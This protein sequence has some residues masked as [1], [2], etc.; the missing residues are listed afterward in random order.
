MADYGVY[1][2]ISNEL[3][4]P[5]IF[6]K[7]ESAEGDCCTYAGPASVPADGQPHA[8]HLND[9]CIGR[10]AEGTAYFYAV[11]QGQLRQYAWYGSCPVW[12]PDNAA[13]GPGATDWN[14]TGHPLTVTVA[15]NPQTPGWTRVSQLIQHV[16]VLMLENRSL[17]HMLGFSGLT[18]TDAATGAPTRVDGL[19]GTESNSYDGRTYPVSQPADWAMPLDPGHEFTDVLA[20]LCGPDAVYQHGTYPSIDNSGYVANYAKSGGTSDP[21]EIMKCYRKGQLPVLAALAEEFALCDGW[22]ASMPGPTWPNR[23]FMMAASAGGLDHSPSLD[24]IAEW[25]TVSGFSFQNGTIFDALTS[26]QRQWRIYRGDQG[27]VAGSLPI[28]AGLKGIPLWDVAPYSDFS[29]D[30]ASGYYPWEF[31]LIE[32]NYGDVISN[33]Y[34]M[35]TSQHPMDDVRHGEALIKSTYEALRNSALWNASLLIVTWDEHGGFYDHAGGVPGGAPSPG[36]QIVTPGNVNKFGFTFR[37]Y[38]PRVPAVIVSPL[39]PKN[40][41]DHRTYDHASIPATVE[42]IFDLGALTQRDLHA[43]DVT[44][45]VSLRQPRPA[46]TVLPDLAGDAA[47]ESAGDRAAAAGARPAAD[48]PV[49][50]GSL[51]GFLQIAL[52]YD[53]ALSPPERRPEILARVSGIRSRAEA[54]RYLQEVGSKAATAKPA[55]T[56]G[57]EAAAQLPDSGA[58]QAQGSGAAFWTY[59]PPR[60]NT[61]QMV[62]QWSVRIEQ[63]DG[64]WS[65]SMTSAQPAQILRAAGVSGMFDVIVVAS[66]PHM[67][68]KQLVPL[69][70][71]RADVRCGAGCRAMVGIVAAPDGADAEYWT[72]WDAVCAPEGG[73][74]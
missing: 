65:G 74:R 47:A 72:A 24:Q 22:R 31:T 66:G 42:K 46:P 11:V 7:F 73:Q 13:S 59:L 9:A 62:T 36:D 54:G 26:N 56:L 20:Q 28:A 37:Q 41:I 4:T 19:T 70:G 64:S 17:D 53:L 43:R 23:F 39:I 63:R 5:L 14:S 51:P 71:Y 10:G 45:L 6:L 57:L 68:E 30:L 48:G 29:A 32:P 33:T 52:R 67:A 15:V 44:S 60:N 55:V 1:F 35:G 50:E 18:G 34:R 21:A 61:Q 25:E 38:G 27:P 69:P 2:Q 58:V 16:F 49:D 12:S 8:V 40:L 3:G